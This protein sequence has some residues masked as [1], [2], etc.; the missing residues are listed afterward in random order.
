MVWFLECEIA[1]AAFCLSVCVGE[2]L[3]N[4]CA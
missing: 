4:T 2:V 3:V 1:L